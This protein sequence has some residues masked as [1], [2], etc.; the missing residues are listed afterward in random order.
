MDRLNRDGHTDSEAWKRTHFIQ[1][2][3]V[4]HGVSRLSG[5]EFAVRAFAERSIIEGKRKTLGLRL[6]E[7]ALAFAR[8]QHPADVILRAAKKIRK[9]SAKTSA[10][11]D[12][13]HGELQL[14]VK[15]TR[16]ESARW[17]AIYN[18][19]AHESE[20]WPVVDTQEDVGLCRNST[21]G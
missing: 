21:S 5:I 16:N 2:I 18:T 3:R 13:T 4:R 12:G 17:R 14:I 1:S 11:G 20:S 6:G 7:L 10:L 15:R 9:D 19:L 8:W